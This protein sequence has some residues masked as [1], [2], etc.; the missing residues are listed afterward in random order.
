[1][2]EEHIVLNSDREDGRFAD[3]EGFVHAYLKHI[4][5]RLE[6][7][8]N[9]KP[10]HFD[11]WRML[12]TE[13]MR[14]L[15]RFP[16]DVPEQPEPRM[17]WAEPRDGYELQK[18]EAY[19]EPYS[20]V[21]Y[22]AL[23]PEGVD[24]DNPV[25]AVMCFP[26]GNSTKE[27]LAGEPELYDWVAEN[28]HPIRNRM[29]WYYAQAGMVAV[30]VDHPGNGEQTRHVFDDRYEYTTH[31]VWAGRNYEGIQVFQKTPILQWLKE[32]DYVDA[33]RIATSGH[34][35]GTK[36]ALHLALLDT[37]IAAVVYNDFTCH[38]RERA[39]ACSLFK[40]GISMYTPGVQEW[41]DYLDVMAAIAPRPFLITEGGRTQHIETLRKAWELAGAPDNFEAHHYP[42]YDTPEKRI[43]D[44]EPLCEGMSVWEYLE[45]ANVD[46]PDHC[47]KENL[48]VPW[49]SQVLGVPGDGD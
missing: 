47:F 38:W 34:S 33:S 19:P 35:F 5:P 27:L 24:A 28:K 22:L 13:K 20:V 1:M 32:R 29:A 30:A 6:F 31:A 14:E 37:S 12:V 11:G 39:V 26:G 43:H 41:F 9:M 23:V 2:N 16:E 3:V 25:P 40:Y 18:W 7:D 42:N 36:P 49:L 15:L 45:Y 4:K 21:P 10:E 17:L 46:A 44:S 48:A 8:P